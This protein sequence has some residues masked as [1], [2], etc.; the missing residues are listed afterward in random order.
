[1]DVEIAIGD[2]LSKEEIEDKFQT[3]FGSCIKGI[4]LRRWEDGTPYIILFSRADGPY[5]DKME[6]DILYYDGEGQGKD[7]GLTTANKVLIESYSTNRTIYGFQ[8]K[9]RGIWKY[10]GVLEVLDYAYINKKGFMT[11]EFKLKRTGLDI[12]EVITS[13]TKEIIKSVKDEPQIK[14]DSTYDNVKRKRRNTAFSK[15]IKDVYDYSCAV[16][17][18]KR[19]THQVTQMLKQPTYTQ[20]Q[21]MAQMT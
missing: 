19:F 16:C 5:S 6:G 10:V 13:E 14:E 4:T 9:E 18:K 17:G 2:E 20:R 1:M 8:Q 7:Q 12:G 11:Y 3:N 15:L 21:K